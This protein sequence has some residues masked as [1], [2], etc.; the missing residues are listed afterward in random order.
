MAE[1]NRKFKP[2]YIRF[3]SALIA[4][5]ILQTIIFSLVISANNVVSSINRNSENTLQ[6]YASKRSIA[7]ET[8]MN[9][10]WSDIKAS[11]ELANQIM[12]EKIDEKGVHITEIFDDT[13]LLNSF[14]SD[15]TAE[16][17]NILRTNDVSDAFLVLCSSA[18]MPD[19]DAATSYRG[20]YFTD[21]DPIN[22]PDDNSDI[23]M[24]KGNSTISSRYNIPMDV[25]W[26]SSFSHELGEI[27]DLDF[28]FDPVIK[29]F[30]MPS[31][32]ASE[33][34]CWSSRCTLTGSS[35]HSYDFI[36]YSIPLACDGQVYGVIG[37]GISVDSVTALLPP[38]EIDGHGHGGYLLV[39]SSDYHSNSQSFTADV[40][41]VTGGLVADAINYGD[42]LKLSS[43]SGSDILRSVKGVTINNSAAYCAAEAIALY[44]ENSP[45]SSDT[46]LILAMIDE[47]DLF[48][49]SGM[50]TSRLLLSS[51][52]SFGIC[53]ILALMLT[54]FVL[55]PVKLLS[56]DAEDIS[57]TEAVPLR[58]NLG[59]EFNAISAALHNLSTERDYLIKEINSKKE[60]HL[61]L[62]RAAECHIFEYD[63]INDSLVIY[64]LENDKEMHNRYQSFRSLVSDGR[65]CHEE[66]I[67]LMLAFT[68]GTSENEFHIRIYEKNGEM[69]WKS[70]VCRPVTD[71]SGKIIRVTACSFDI[72]NQKLEEEEHLR[73]EQ[74]DKLTG[75]YSNEYGRMLVKKSILE[76]E[77]SCYN[78]AVFSLKNVNNFIQEHGAYYFDGIIEEIGNILRMYSTTDDIIWRKN[79]SDIA[80]YSNAPD[81]DT[82]RREISNALDCIAKIYYGS[83]ED[84]FIC[85]VGISENQPGTP[86]HEALDKTVQAECAAEMPIYP[87]ICYYSD[88]NLDVNT[89]AALIS[90]K[91]SASTADHNTINSGFIVTDNII[92]YSLNM[93]EKSV[94]VSDALNLVF[95]KTGYTLG[96]DRIAAYEINHDFMT[97]SIL[98]QWCRYELEKLD[99]KTIK[100]DMADFEKML[101]VSEGKD[102]VIIENGYAVNSNIINNLVSE[103]CGDK[104]MV[105]IPSYE[106]D[107]LIGCISASISGDEFTDETMSALKEICK[108]AVTHIIKSIKSNESKAKSEF[109]SSMS[110]EIRTPMNAIMGMTAIALRNNELSEDTKDCLNKIDSSAKYLLALI[111]DILDMSRIE[112]GK[113]TV[114]NAFL[115]INEIVS[116]ADIINRTRIEEKGNR[117]T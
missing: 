20:V 32:P 13:A 87:D 71:S 19:P 63:R 51:L 96:F 17:L 101:S 48:E 110:H 115:D 38:G 97:V 25:S 2:I 94:H 31:V 4:L 80:V 65:V 28:F 16:L 70:V 82:Y 35:D 36:S 117:F 103:F 109:L 56:D 59:V 3:A 57:E 22:N 8:E 21:S 61:M 74:L 53:T 89:R 49:T 95:C 112:S 84:N 111:N 1:R 78:I 39:R 91:Y 12:T 79:I 92:S 34:G 24:L 62:L 58:E 30:S 81:K 15:V 72:T 107:R 41:A 29:A 116:Q 88:I 54:A 10:K 26:S 40:Q 64:R 85:Q 100:M 67:P 106:K 50:L 18:E 14:T 98:S 6:Q 114:D 5:V 75:F 104:K 47:E 83:E 27:S 102:S 68:D 46:W 45:Y 55:R 76:S 99:E 23:I 77:N 108:I 9:G 60:R 43:V 52:V 66:D 93:L 33:L 86:M 42:E 69:R 73:Q 113:M 11:A 37:A 44:P 90:S 7:L 105:I